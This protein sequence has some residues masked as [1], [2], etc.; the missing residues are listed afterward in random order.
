[1]SHKLI[2]AFADSKQAIHKQ[3]HRERAARLPRPLFPFFF[4]KSDLFSFFFFFSLNLETLLSL[5]PSSLAL[6]SPLV[7]AAADRGPASL[8]PLSSFNLPISFWCYLCA[9]IFRKRKK[10]TPFFNRLSLFSLSQKKK[11]E[12][13]NHAT[14]TSSSSSNSANGSLHPFSGSFPP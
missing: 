1:M 7:R 4:P 2:N 14:M 11:E 8:R 6:L 3:R 5:P 12:E 9:C 13:K 10:T